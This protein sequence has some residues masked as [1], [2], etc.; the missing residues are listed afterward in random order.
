LNKA[1]DDLARQLLAKERERTGVLS[2]I[3]QKSGMLNDNYLKRQ[4][5]LQQQMLE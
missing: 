2:I 5:D 4:H 3:K 1:L